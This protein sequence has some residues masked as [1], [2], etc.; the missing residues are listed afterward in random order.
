MQPEIHSLTAPALL[1]YVIIKA[2]CIKYVNNMEILLEVKIVRNC[3]V[4]VRII[5]NYS[6][7]IANINRDILH[8]VYLIFIFSSNLVNLCKT[9]IALRLCAFTTTLKKV[10]IC[11]CNSYSLSLKFH[12]Y[13][14]LTFTTVRFCAS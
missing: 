8:G 1:P 12:T 11:P 10:K 14:S 4:G 7:T 3:L 5:I 9:H 2:M 13:T 6:F